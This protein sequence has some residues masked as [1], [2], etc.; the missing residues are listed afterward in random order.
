MNRVSLSNKS[1]FLT[2]NL[3][4]G[5]VEVDFDHVFSNCSQFVFCGNF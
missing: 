3:S 2:Y 1:Q 4:F 5:S